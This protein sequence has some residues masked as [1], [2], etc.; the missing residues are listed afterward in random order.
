MPGSWFPHLAW[1]CSGPTPTSCLHTMRRARRWQA[2]EFYPIRTIAWNTPSKIDDAKQR[3]AMIR[4]HIAPGSVSGYEQSGVGRQPGTQAARGASV[5]KQFR[6]AS[7]CYAP[8]RAS[9]SDFPDG[10]AAPSSADSEYTS[11]KSAP[12]SIWA[13]VRSGGMD[14]A[15]MLY[16]AM[17]LLIRVCGDFSVAGVKP[18][19]A[20]KHRQGWAPDH[21]LG[22]LGGYGVI[23]AT[24]KA[25][26][27]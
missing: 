2:T 27:R 16:A 15:W 23:D 9:L 17:T 22:G 8:T 11:R 26:F 6:A 3:R 10:K 5:T 12:T 24:R 18:T 20:G 25:V 13:R 4:K 21:L 1:N 19:F 7:C 14:E